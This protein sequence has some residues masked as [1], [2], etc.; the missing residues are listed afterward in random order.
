[1]IFLNGLF[2]IESRAKSKPVSL[3]DCG[4]MQNSKA[5]VK[6]GIDH[7]GPLPAGGTRPI[8]VQITASDRRT[9]QQEQMPMQRTLFC[10]KRLLTGFP[11]A[12][13]ETSTRS[14]SID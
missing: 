1:L 12:N 2:K 8:H 4:R 10:N 3:S 9:G 5:L 6:T 14:K 13:G 11:D 7:P